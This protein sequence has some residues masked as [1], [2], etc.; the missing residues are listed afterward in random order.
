MIYQNGKNRKL[1]IRREMENVYFLKDYT[2][3]FKRDYKDQNGLNKEMRK[4]NIDILPNSKPI[5]KSPYKLAHKCKDIFQ[6]E[7]KSM[8]ATNIVYPFDKVE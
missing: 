2:D 8:L 1:V 3:V 7:T 5:K 6:D 4:M